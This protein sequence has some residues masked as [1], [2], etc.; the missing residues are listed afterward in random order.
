MGAEGEEMT[1]TH[2]EIGGGEKGGKDERRKGE[3]NLINIFYFL[4]LGAGSWLV[5]L[6]FMRHLCNSYNNFLCHLLELALMSLC[7]SH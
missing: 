5:A 3:T 4:D 2:N 7:H 6:G 1:E